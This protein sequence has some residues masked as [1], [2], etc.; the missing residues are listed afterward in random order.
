MRL[1]EAVLACRFSFFSYDVPRIGK[2]GSISA[3]RYKFVPE[4]SGA[5]VKPGVFVGPEICEPM[6]NNDFKG[7]LKL[8]ESAAWE[9]LV[10]VVQNFLGNHR[11]G[12]YPE[13]VDNMLKAYLLMSARMSLKTHFL[14]SHLNFFPPNL[15]DVSD[16]HGERFHRDIKVMESR[17]GKFNQSTMSEFC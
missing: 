4:K 17:Q 12:T 1:V 16:E 7:K 2:L 13:P 10:Q 11:E 15:G 5:N 14:H 6:L 9:A 8:T 3:L